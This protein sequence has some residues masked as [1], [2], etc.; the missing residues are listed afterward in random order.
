MRRW[1]LIFLMVLLPLQL[2]WAAV[3]SYCEHESSGAT[4]QHLGH[5]EHQ[6]EIDAGPV[7]SSNGKTTGTSGA[8]DLDCGT[9][10]A[11]GCAVMLQPLKVLMVKLPSKTHSEPALHLASQPASLP[12]RPNWACLA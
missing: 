9:C 10:H 5:H 4:T 7:D 2:S 8:V 11:G 6:H 1:L 3:A 12:E